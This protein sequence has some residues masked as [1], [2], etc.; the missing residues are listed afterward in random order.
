MSPMSV[1]FVFVPVAIL[2]EIFHA[3]SV[4]IFVTAGLGIV[5]LAHMLGE[6]TEHVS[7]HV[8]PGLGGF[9][10]AT[11]GN[12]T[13]LI[14]GMMA[15]WRASQLQLASANPPP[16]KTAAQLLQGAEEMIDVV[17][18]SITG[19]IIGNL[20]F[21]L[22]LAFLVGG[23]GREKQVFSDKVVGVGNAMMTLA[24]AGLMVPSII[25]WLDKIT[26]EHSHHLSDE[27]YVHLSDHV[28]VVLL[29]IYVLSLVF[30]F[31]TH[32]HL[33]RLPEDEDHAPAHTEPAWS[34]RKAV[35]VLVGATVVIAGLSEILV[36]SL[37]EAGKAMGLNPI[38]MGLFVVALV[39][40]AAEHASAVLIA[41]RDKMDLA[42]NIAMGSSM[43]VALL[44]APILVLASNLTAKSMTLV[45]KPLEVAAVGISV[46]ITTIVNLDGES[47][48][49]EG[50]QLLSVYAILGL[51]FYH[52]F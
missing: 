3:G 38:F 2:A 10:N 43:Q 28:A 48:W 25:Y 23:L 49:L 34:I 27:T 5:P 20:L 26:T 44:L 47:N 37:E 12:A 32:K 31:K 17:K 30:S 24:V 29:V 6:A 36:G 50:C 33:Y 21:I 52:A 1:L 8:G 18:A 19:S 16:G 40:N 4:V 9:L 35:G 51:A 46:A 45:F 11:F 42:I 22:G 41:K 13:E 14:I 15:I 7:D 39:G